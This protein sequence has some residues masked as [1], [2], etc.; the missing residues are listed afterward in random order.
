MG[1]E[2]YNHEFDELYKQYNIENAEGTE[3]M[4]PYP[5][6]LQAAQSPPNAI[7]EGEEFLYS[8]TPHLH[9]ANDVRSRPSNARASCLIDQ[10]LMME[11]IAEI[12]GEGYDSI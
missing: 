10:E 9:I 8:E 3:Q 1:Y 11:K 7:S 12:S 6:N 4:Q 2:D 5:Y